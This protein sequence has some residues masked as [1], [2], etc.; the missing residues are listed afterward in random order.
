MLQIASGLIKLINSERCSFNAK[1][2]LVTSVF[3]YTL[4]FYISMTILYIVDSVMLPSEILVTSCYWG[5]QA[6]WNPWSSGSGCNKR[7][8]SSVNGVNTNAVYILR[9]KT[10]TCV[11]ALIHT[12][13]HTHTPTHTHAFTRVLIPTL[14]HIHNIYVWGQ[15]VIDEDNFLNSVST[16]KGF[17]NPRRSGA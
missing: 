5:V 10:H 11:Y 17:E 12:H 9:M 3:E 8:L 15:L 7:Q 16:Y 1:V 13:V 14:A 2:L 6:K 4:K